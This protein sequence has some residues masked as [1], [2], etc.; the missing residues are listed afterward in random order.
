VVSEEALDEALELI[1]QVFSTTAASPVAPEEVPAKLEQSMGLGKNSWPL[2]AIRKMADVFL[3]NAAGRRKSPAF[4]VRWLNL[5][6]FCLRPGFGFPGDD[7]RIEQARRIYAQGLQYGNQVQCE[8]EWWI[9]WGRVAGGLNRNQQVDIYQRLSPLLLPKANKKVRINS[10]LLREMWR[11]AA[12]LELLP[13]GT[14]TE[15]G[16]AIV[17]RVKARQFTESDLWCLSRL[18]ARKLFYGPINLVVPPA[19]A[20]R[21]VEALLPIDKAAEAMALIARRTEDPVRDLSPTTQA[22]VRRRLESL[23]G[24][25]RYIPIL[26]GEEEDERALGRIFGEELPSGLVFAAEEE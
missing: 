19:A 1:R 18:G 14:K 16:D 21:W 11:T 25:E 3:E 9:F 20:T 22:A 10:S 23:P 12:S 4:E 24:G 17:R 2:D 5:C 7:W 8:I 6:G 13:V 15:L 26:E